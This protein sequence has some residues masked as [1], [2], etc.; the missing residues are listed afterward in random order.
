MRLAL[1]SWC[2][3]T[4]PSKRTLSLAPE[5]QFGAPDGTHT[6]T[7]AKTGVQSHPPRASDYTSNRLRIQETSDVL[8]V[9][10]A[11]PVVKTLQ[12]DGE[13][14]GLTYEDVLPNRMHELVGWSDE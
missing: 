10:I 7:G 13:D 8:V 12:M 4:T 14:R 9:N 1:R 3:T 11:M 2:S 6:M 5:L